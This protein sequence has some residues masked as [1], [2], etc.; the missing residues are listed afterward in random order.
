MT[1]YTHGLFDP[2]LHFE[3]MRRALVAALCLS[4][5]T[6]P[7]GVILTHRRLSLIGDTMSHAVLPGAAIGYMIAG[8]SLVHMSIGGLVAGLLVAFLSGITSRATGQ[9]E[10]TSLAAFYLISLALGVIL[11]AV[12]GST[13]DLLHILFGSLL[14][15]ND[16]ALLLMASITTL[17]LITLAV[18]YRGL[19]AECLD[20]AFLKTMGG[21]G[22]VY[23]LA[24]L[25]LVVLNLI[26]SFMA[27]GTL[28][29]VGLLILPAASARFISN[30]VPQMMALALGIA[31]F[32]SVAGLLVSY[33]WSVP[34]GPSIVLVAG[35]IYI[36]CLLCGP[37][38]GVLTR[39]LKHRHLTR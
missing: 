28:M 30:Q 23:H 3:F 4:A 20:S 11:I 6:A 1:N 5:G 19:I 13:L 17:T 29:S 7:L 2:F 26:G 36:I 32:S 12:K 24:F 14:A 33:H 27:L 15:V 22:A 37:V 21:N 25:I 39:K 31:A 38:N 35:E 18:I 9:G 8:F 34:S 16:T 10:D